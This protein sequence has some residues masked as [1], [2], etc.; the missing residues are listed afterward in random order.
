MCSYKG[1]FRYGKKAGKGI[2]QTR[3]GTYQ[4]Q[5]ENDYLNGD[6]TFV[7]NDGKVYEGDFKRTKMDGEGKIYYPNGQIAKGRW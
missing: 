3:A 7:W 4:G 5:F 2:L 1:Y 6:G